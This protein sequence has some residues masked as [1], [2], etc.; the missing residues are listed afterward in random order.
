M[1]KI[2]NACLLAAS[3]WLVVGCATSKPPPEL[4]DARNTYQRVSS[5]PT[6]ELAPKELASAKESLDQAEHAFD[7]GYDYY[8]TRDVAYIAKRKAELAEVQGK[9]TVAQRQNADASQR[10]AALEAEEAR[11]K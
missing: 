4:V 11:R 1:K 6:R 10:L 2:A 7:N 3:G 5:G 8:Y 9:I